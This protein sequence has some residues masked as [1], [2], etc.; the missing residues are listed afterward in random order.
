MAQRDYV[1]KKAKVKNTSR[2]IPNLM[3]AIAVLLVIL[4]AAILYFVSTNKPNKPA[5]T[6][7]IVTQK[8]QATLPDK[9]EERWTYLKELEN[10]NSHNQTIIPPVSKSVQEKE[11]QQILN[12]FINDKQ[13][14]S[15][16]SNQA[17]T[18]TAPP[19]VVTQPNTAAQAGN[20]LLQCGA[21]EDKANAES[22]QAK[23]AM[24]GMAS[25]VQRDKVHRVL[26]GPYKL[27]KDAEKAIVILTNKGITCFVTLK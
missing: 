18:N 13:T 14:S 25:F 10:P 24:I 26:V 19:A 6:P 12:S 9:P 22:L 2:V 4:F 23:L 3:M 21:F 7:Q 5:A 8:P 17:Q 16:A 1:K 20:W 27:K 15:T 11:R